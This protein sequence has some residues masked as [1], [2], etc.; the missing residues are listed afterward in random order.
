MNVHNKVDYPVIFWTLLLLQ[1][2]EVEA[3][4]DGPHNKLVEEVTKQ[5]KTN[6][7]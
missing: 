5:N 4:N 2:P 6:L 3:C 7:T 1:R